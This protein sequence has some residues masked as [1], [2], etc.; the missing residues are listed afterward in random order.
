MYFETLLLKWIFRCILFKKNRT[1]FHTR[2]PLSSSRSSFV[3]MSKIINTMRAFS[4]PFQLIFDEDCITLVQISEPRL[5]TIDFDFESAS[6]G[7]VLVTDLTKCC[8][9]S[10]I[11]VRHPKRCSPAFQCGK[12]SSEIFAL[13]VTNQ[14]QST[15]SVRYHLWNYYYWAVRVNKYFHIPFYIPF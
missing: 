15:S 8:S 12:E 11:H 6:A 5:L 2:S 3:C 7:R 1:N 14:S 9:H 10:P 4:N 13:L